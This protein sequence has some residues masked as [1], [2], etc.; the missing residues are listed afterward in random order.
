MNRPSKV[1]PA[2]ITVRTAT[3]ADLPAA[4]EVFW[5]CWTR[6]YPAFAD[7]EVLARLTRADAEAMWADA[8][9]LDRALVAVADDGRVVGLVRYGVADSV[10]EIHSLYVD[11]ELQGGGV[12]GRLLAAATGDGLVHGAGDSALWVFADNSTAR[13]FYARHGFTPDG[14]SRTTDRFGLPEARLRRSGTPIGTLASL[15]VTDPL[16]EPVETAPAGQGVVSTSSTNMTPPTGAVVGSWTPA[17]GVLTA[18]AGVRGP[19]G[20]PMTTDTVHDLASVTKLFTTAA[21]LRLTSSGEVALDDPLDTYL[22]FPEPVPTVR[23]L[24]QH[25]SG[26]L[27]WQ[28]LYLQVGDTDLQRRD[29]TAALDLIRTLPRATAPD[30]QWNYSD[31]GFILLGAVINTVTGHDLRTAVAELITEP[32]GIDVG[33]GPRSTGDLAS[34]SLDDRVE[35]RMVATGE[36]H[37]VIIEGTFSRW[38][39]VPSTGEVNDGNAHHALGGVSGH[40]GLFAS[41]DDL[42]TFGRALTHSDHGLWGADVL[43]EFLTPGP[44]PEQGLG[45]RLRELGPGRRLAWHPGFTGTA[46][47]ICPGPDPAVV[48]LA[49]N[50][51]VTEATPVPTVRLWKCVLRGLG[52]VPDHREQKADHRVRAASE[53]GEDRR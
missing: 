46:L 21:V 25:R 27:P 23:Q 36:P 16:V 18:A 28:P 15:L 24:L 53:D 43:A 10:T 4:V 19:D 40:A 7:P 11:P 30:Q 41:V 2:K 52:L 14:T 22:P 32:L 38:R 42:I 47:G 48:A 17:N 20:A 12:G 13:D 33:Y 6:S 29:P 39:D 35:R 3:Q 37:P 44:D 50:R 45:F 9:A 34:S 26:L 8:W 31:L 1:T 49:T 5:T 51:L